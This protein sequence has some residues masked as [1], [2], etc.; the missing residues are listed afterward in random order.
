MAKSLPR[1]TLVRTLQ[2]FSLKFP[3]RLIGIGSNVGAQ[4]APFWE[5]P[6]QMTWAKGNNE[7]NVPFSAYHPKYFRWDLSSGILL[8]KTF[9]LSLVFPYRRSLKPWESIDQVSMSTSRTHKC[10]Y[11][12]KHSCTRKMSEE[13]GKK[14]K[15][16]WNVFEHSTWLR[17]F[18]REEEG[19]ECSIF[20]GKSLATS[21]LQAAH[22]TS[23]QVK[24]LLSNIVGA[25]LVDQW[26]FDLH[27]EFD[28][29]ENPN[30]FCLI[31]PEPRSQL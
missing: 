23:S 30:F 9:T 5:F 2:L 24:L 17:P 18:S 29:L 28:C 20:G 1:F 3:T 26:S 22:W 6:Q 10:S 15:S 7:V 21:N 31:F 8:R 16:V 11:S 19:R 13:I 4:R 12:L 14:H 27:I 25:K